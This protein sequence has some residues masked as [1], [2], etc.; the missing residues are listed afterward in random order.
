M[1]TMIDFLNLM[2]L[3]SRNSLIISIYSRFS[4]LL[5]NNYILYKLKIKQN[6]VLLK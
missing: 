4:L 6:E 1:I 3:T 2:N 5:I